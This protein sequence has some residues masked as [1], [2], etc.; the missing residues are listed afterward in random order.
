M[1]GKF[2]LQLFLWA[3][4]ILEFGSYLIEDASIVFIIRIFF[5]VLKN[6]LAQ[7][8][9]QVSGYYTRFSELFIVLSPRKRVVR[10]QGFCFEFVTKLSEL[11]SV[12]D[13]TC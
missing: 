8:E 5:Q 10:K 2:Q 6:H 7:E 1:L 13:A 11:S 3:S 9:G 4:F 12:I